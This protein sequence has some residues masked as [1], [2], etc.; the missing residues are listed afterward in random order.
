MEPFVDSSAHLQVHAR[1][2]ENAVGDLKPPGVC[3][4]Q[5]VVSPKSHKQRKGHSII[6]MEVLSN[7]CI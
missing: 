7:L 3:P 5:H 1:S 6:E 4:K 2:K